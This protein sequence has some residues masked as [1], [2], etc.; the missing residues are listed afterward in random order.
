MIRLTT[1]CCKSDTVCCALIAAF[2]LLT[3]VVSAQEP[4]A[5]PATQPLVVGE[6]L[7]VQTVGNQQT[8]TLEIG[9]PRDEV[10]VAATPTIWWTPGHLEESVTGYNWVPGYWIEQVQDLELLSY[11]DSARAS[12]PTDFADRRS[13]E[14]EDLKRN[15]QELVQRKLQG[16]IQEAR[17]RERLE[18]ERKQ[19]EIDQAW[20]RLFQEKS[21][22]RQNRV[23][24]L[25]GDPV[26][27]SKTRR[28]L[29]EARLDRALN[30]GLTT[31]QQQLNN[32]RAEI[33][34][35]RD[36]F[37]R[38]QERQRRQADVRAQLE[39]DQQL[40]DE[41]ARAQS[42]QDRRAQEQA[43][44]ARDRADREARDRA[45]EQQRQ[46]RA[47]EQQRHRTELEREQRR[48]EQEARRADRN[49]N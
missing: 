8:G 27:A 7:P 2:A 49:R 25:A 34:R 26:A 42:D 1:T 31:E 30:Q 33:Q 5:K 29:L 43:A 19:F 35:N 32:Q 47:M 38:A 36:E 24:P 14:I 48:Q 12:Q 11:R 44:L 21:S 4:I 13:I 6:I 15:R 23:G 46:A 17:N 3:T 9:T 40:R 16:Q 37:F 18:R 22:S 20:R 45:R 41:A 39:R 28:Q 10:L